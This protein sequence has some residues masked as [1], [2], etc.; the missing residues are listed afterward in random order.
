MKLISYNN[1]HCIH[2]QINLTRYLINI[3]KVELHLLN[4]KNELIIYNL[5]L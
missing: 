4:T 3:V 2:I 5:I 1:Q